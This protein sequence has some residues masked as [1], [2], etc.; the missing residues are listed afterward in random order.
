MQTTNGDKILARKKF[1]PALY[2]ANDAKGKG[3]VVAHL[4][5]EGSF[6]NAAE[7]TKHDVKEMALKH[8]EVE[9][10][11]GWTGA[12]F[13]YETIH[14]PYRKKR[15]M[16][17]PFTYWVLNFECTHALTI[18]SED[19]SGCPIVGVSNKY[20]PDGSEEFYDV[21]TEGFTLVKL[22]N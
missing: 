8:H 16:N 11:S 10:R 15:L 5:K 14:I 3:A 1:D 4:Q 7:D 18:E 20:V 21:P 2:R 22:K 17:K 19:I 9:V 13:P 6:V 12:N